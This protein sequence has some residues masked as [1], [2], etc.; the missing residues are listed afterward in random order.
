MEIKPYI[1]FGPLVF[2][3]SSREDCVRFLDAPA[4]IRINR[5]EVEELH[6][7][8]YIV[9][10]DRSTHTVRE[11]TLLPHADAT[12]DGIKVTWDQ[13]FLRRVCER[14]GSPRNVHGFI[15]LNHLGIAVTGIHD[16]DD[17]Q[18]AIGAFSKGDF[19]DLLTDSVP[20]EIPV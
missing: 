20:F 14:D 3:Q 8:Q 11:C 7:G 19:D 15:V 17:S 1:S 5:E 18:L 2:G 16:N 9:R 13:N 12:I 6:Y 4:H 10:L